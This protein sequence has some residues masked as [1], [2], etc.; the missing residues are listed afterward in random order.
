MN[1]LDHRMITKSSL[2]VLVSFCFTVFKVLTSIDQEIFGARR[3]DFQPLPHKSSSEPVNM[4]SCVSKPKV[5]DEPTAASESELLL[6]D[7][8]SPNRTNKRFK[9]PKADSNDVAAV[10]GAWFV[11]FA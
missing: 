1:I 5:D 3:R 4:G 10:C 9:C 7:T 2:S 11:K 6:T 8:V